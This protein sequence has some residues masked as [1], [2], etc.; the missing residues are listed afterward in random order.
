M[1]R[2]AYLQ[3]ATGVAGD[4]FLGA[5][6]SAGVPFGYLSDK[7]ALL[8]IRDEFELRQEGVL[9]NGQL[10][11]K[12]HVEV[13]SSQRRPHR[14]FADIAEI[15]DNSGLPPAVKEKSIEIFRH[16][17]VAEAKVH[18]TTVEK[19]HFHE[20]GAVDAIVDIVGTCIG[21]DYLGVERLYCSPLPVGG[22]TVVTSH[23]TLPV[24]VPAVLQMFQDRQVPVY[25]NGIERELVT[26]TGAAIVTT[27]AVDFGPPPAMK[28]TK[29][30]LGAGSLDLPLPNI[31]RLWLGETATS[32][33][34]EEVA[35]LETQID[36]CNPQILAHVATELL[37][38]GALD[39]FQQP[40]A[41]KKNRLGTLLT[42]ICEL[43]KINICE[44]FLFGHTTTLGIRRQIQTRA[45]LERQ[46][47]SVKTKFGD[48][49]VK[50]AYHNGE[51]LNVQPEYEDC[52][53]ISQ[54]LQI[55]LHLIHLEAEYQA[56]LSL[57]SS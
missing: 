57:L 30:G 17:A 49:R 4:M 32:P 27:L 35:V 50:I 40:V 54:S 21:L 2:I 51:I 34:L 37:R 22:G 52:L 44:N 5:L 20:V 33:L 6:V 48:V 8:T 23:G 14:H 43:D 56:R 55:P 24:P 11:T 42:V 19:V 29:I 3:C 13:F 7:L 39:V 53:R 47:V 16:L 25:S 46:I 9:K 1:S 26:P 36:D 31:L 45:V 18:G 28:I 10:A 15:I 38:L 12:I 41:M